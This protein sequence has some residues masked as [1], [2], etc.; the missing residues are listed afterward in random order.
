MTLTFLAQIPSVFGHNSYTSMHTL[1]FTI[2][3][4]WGNLQD[5]YYPLLLSVIV[6]NKG[7]CDRF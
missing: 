5:L 4:E 2:L 3:E 1:P 7:N 6:Y